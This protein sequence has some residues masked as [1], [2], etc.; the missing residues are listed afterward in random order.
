MTMEIINV[1]SQSVVSFPKVECY[2]F[3][4]LAPLQFFLAVLKRLA[5]S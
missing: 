4:K 2:K 5:V 3:S 1:H